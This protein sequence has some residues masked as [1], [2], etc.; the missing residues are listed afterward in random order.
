MKKKKISKNNSLPSTHSL[1]PSEQLV[2]V[3]TGQRVF[4]DDVLLARLFPDATTDGIASSPMEV[5]PA[6][7]E[8]AMG[9]CNDG[10]CVEIGEK[11]GCELD[12]SLK[13][14]KFC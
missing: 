10:E 1:H 6:E 13:L 3:T 5:Q 11:K 8:M 2:A 9:D 12:N 4:P 7:K 14:Y